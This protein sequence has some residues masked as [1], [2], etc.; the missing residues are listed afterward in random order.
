MP[1]PPTEPLPPRTL[2]ATVIKAFDLTLERFFDGPA[3]E[4][5]SEELIERM[6]RTLMARV[7]ERLR[8]AEG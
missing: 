7:V 3:L 6:R 8:E 5:A 1:A 4:L 2:P